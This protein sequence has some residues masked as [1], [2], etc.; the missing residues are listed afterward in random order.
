M[1]LLGKRAISFIFSMKALLTFLIILL[2]FSSLS[3]QW[4]ERIVTEQAVSPQKVIAAD[5]DGDG[6]LDIVSMNFEKIEWYRNLGDGN[7]S[8]GILVGE[9]INGQDIAVADI[10]GDGDLDIVGVRGSFYQTFNIFFYENIDG[11]GSFETPNGISSPHTEGGLRVMIVDIDANGATDIL[12]T[13]NS[14]RKLTWYKN[15]GNGNFDEG[16]VISSGYI[17]GFSLDV[18]DIDGDGDIDIVVNTPNYRITSWFR[19]LDG[20]GNFGSPIE[21]GSRNLNLQSLFLMDIDRDGDLDLIG[22]SVNLG[23][24]WWEN[25]DGQGN[26]GL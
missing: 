24:F 5:I 26:F 1:A 11:N 13:T 15:L 20:E 4:Q 18:G 25:L 10:D 17:S 9:L 12:A 19:N 23:F 2:S 3:A 8:E 16:T 22:S 6:W 7:F 14:D 21:I